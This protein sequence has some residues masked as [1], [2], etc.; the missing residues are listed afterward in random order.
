MLKSVLKFLIVA[1]VLACGDDPVCVIPPCPFPLAVV[2][3]V[4]A[5]TSQV[6]ITGAF[7]RV[8]G[9]SDMPC[10]GGAVSPCIVSGYAGTYQLDIGA[11]G[12]QTVH[13]TVEVTGKSAG[14][15]TCAQVDTQHLDVALVPTT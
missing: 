10:T 14:C 8:P 1:S 12:F 15:G 11:P 4:H 9:Y 2:L 7:V 6:G 3:T 5:S 13:R